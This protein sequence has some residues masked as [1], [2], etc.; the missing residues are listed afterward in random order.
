MLLT[1]RSMAANRYRAYL[2]FNACCFILF[3]LAYSH[4]AWPYSLPPIHKALIII[5]LVLASIGHFTLL[6][7]IV[8][9]PGL[10]LLLIRPQLKRTVH[11]FLISCFSIA[12]T[13]FCVDFL[14][15]NAY[16]FHLSNVILAMFFSK[17]GSEIFDFSFKEWLIAIVAFIIIVVIQRLFLWLANKVTGKITSFLMNVLACIALISLLSSYLILAL[18]AVKKP[19]EVNYLNQQPQ[20]LPLY[21]TVLVCA[22]PVKNSQKALRDLGASMFYQLDKTDQTLQYPLEPLQCEAPKKPPNIVFIV[23]DTWRFD[24]LTA[25]VTPHVRQFADQSIWFQNHRSGGN[26]TQPGIFSLFYG[27]PGTYW[28]AMLKQERSPLLIN[29]LQK[30]HY[31]FAIFASAPLTAPAFYKNVFLHV[32]NLALSTPGES[33]NQRDHEITKRFHDF[34][35]Q[36]TSNA[37]PF[38]GFLFYDEA[39]SFCIA[40]HVDKP[41]QPVIGECSRLYRDNS[42]NPL[43]YVHRYWNSLLQVDK[44]VGLVL[45]DLT[46]RGLLNNTIVVITGDHGQEF[47]DNHQNYWGH[48]G[49][50]TKYQLNTPMVIYWPGM[51]PQVVQYETSHYD[52][53]PTLLQKVFACKAPTNRY[54]V[55]QSIFA[56]HPQKYFLAAGY[57]NFG[58][59][60][61]EQIT[62]IYTDGLSITDKSAKPLYDSCLH[63]AVVQAAFA[64]MNRFYINSSSK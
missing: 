40:Q 7:F 15:F 14:T 29:E 47:N 57:I 41:Y 5:F 23:I 48:A 13:L 33:V 58:I 53:V 28:T 56:P 31:D 30:N 64:D 50:F 22:L 45:D 16:H 43:P 55:G 44:Q 35:Q 46:Q 60:E 62:T 6:A 21:N 11:F 17:A 20:V 24:A 19:G 61:P 51:K 3:G 25:K 52:I 36:R 34:L 10:L 1:D 37:P 38:F 59:V 39:H 2:L 32:P 49:N 63:P 26:G 18:S 27:L 4:Y 54:S 42:T 8:S 12:T 9:L